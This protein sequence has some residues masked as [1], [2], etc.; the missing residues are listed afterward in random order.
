MKDK[1]RKGKGLG[2]DKQLGG[3]ALHNCNLFHKNSWVCTKIGETAQK[4][5]LELALCNDNAASFDKSDSN[6]KR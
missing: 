4:L 3:W 1:T 5:N 6:Q 2:D